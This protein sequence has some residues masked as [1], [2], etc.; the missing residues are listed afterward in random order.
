MA[1]DREREQPRAE[2]EDAGERGNCE[3]QR[4]APPPLS[5]SP[6]SANHERA[7]RDL[8]YHHEQTDGRNGERRDLHVAVADVRH[9]VRE[10]AFELAAAT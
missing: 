4:R 7:G 1:R 8:R 9:L 3:E 5:S 6:Q 2:R 10:H